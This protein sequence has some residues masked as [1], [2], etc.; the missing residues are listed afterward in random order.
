[1]LWVERVTAE[2]GGVTRA[3]RRSRRYFQGI[4]KW[5]RNE[6]WKR[7]KGKEI[8]K[9]RMT[10]MVRMVKEKGDGNRRKGK[11]RERVSFGVMPMLG[12]EVSGWSAGRWPWVD[13]VYECVSGSRL[14][15]PWYWKP[16]ASRNELTSSFLLP[17]TLNDQNGETKGEWSWVKLGG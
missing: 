16:W 4:L 5:R 2:R 1:M 3:E 11:E 13:Q 12:P 7:W 14:F 8:W 9:D 10:G 6:K 15:H 17:L